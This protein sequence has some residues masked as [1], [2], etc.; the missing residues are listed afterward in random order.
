[1]N[2]YEEWVLA[3]VIERDGARMGHL[4]ETAPFGRDAVKKAVKSL[5]AAG[6]ISREGVTL[7]PSERNRLKPTETDVADQLKPTETDELVSPHAPLPKD[8]K[9]GSNPARDAMSQLRHSESW[10]YLVVCTWREFREGNGLCDFAHQSFFGNRNDAY[11]HFKAHC[12]EMHASKRWEVALVERK[13]G[14]NVETWS[15]DP[16]EPIPYEVAKLGINAYIKSQLEK[17]RI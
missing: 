17:N 7:F 10:P 4:Y 6:Q 1:M 8:L 13:T 11:A 9:T 15:T 14:E 12:R 3:H 5:V 2:R 16:Y